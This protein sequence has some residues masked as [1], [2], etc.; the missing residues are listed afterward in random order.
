VTGSS[1]LISGAFPT[2]IQLIDAVFP[3]GYP[4]RSGGRIE[5]SSKSIPIPVVFHEFRKQCRIDRMRRRIRREVTGDCLIIYD[6]FSYDGRGLPVDNLDEV[7]VTGIVRVEDE[8]WET[9]VGDP[10]E[11]PTWLRLAVEANKMALASGDN[12][13]V[14]FE[15]VEIKRTN[16]E[17]VQILSLDMGS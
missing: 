8:I 4:S 9:Y 11:N 5:C 7:A 12:H 13:H 16:E 17:G 1:P 15:G 2:Q 6:A 14:F 3:N 10:I